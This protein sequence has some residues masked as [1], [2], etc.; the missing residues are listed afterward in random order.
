MIK[1]GATIRD[2]EEGLRNGTLQIQIERKVITDDLAYLEPMEKHLK[3][4]TKANASRERLSRKGT[5]DFLEQMDDDEHD[6]A[7]MAHACSR[8]PRISAHGARIS[9]LSQPAPCPAHCT[10]C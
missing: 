8:A 3:D 10:I 1:A 4:Y 9:A 5:K 6:D 7:P 2:I